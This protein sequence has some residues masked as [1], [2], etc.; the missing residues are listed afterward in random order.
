MTSSLVARF[1]SVESR[2]TIDRWQSPLLSCVSKDVSHALI[3][4][5]T[6]ARQGSG[7][8]TP[9]SERKNESIMKIRRWCWILLS[10]LCLWAAAGATPA[11]K[12]TRRKDH[13][14]SSPPPSLTAAHLVSWGHVGL[15]LARTHVPWPLRMPRLL[16]ETLL[17]CV[18]HSESAQSLKALMLASTA[19][20][21]IFLWT[22]DLSVIA[23]MRGSSY[24]DLLLSAHSLVGGLVYLEAALQ[25][26]KW[27]QAAER[28]EDY[29]RL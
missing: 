2:Q 24:D 12:P 9:K 13:T 7:F 14:Y 16:W 23:W 22:P 29:A 27:Q 28:Q 26:R 11:D 10:C 18:L 20:S 3:H 4:A 19:V 21:D 6:R 15:N 5:T 25:V 1:C 17:Q 8:I